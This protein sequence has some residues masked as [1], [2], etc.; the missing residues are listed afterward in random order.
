MI[1]QMQKIS[2]FCIGFLYVVHQGGRQNIRVSVE[3]VGPFLL[4][5]RAAG[6]KSGRSDDTAATTLSRPGLYYTEN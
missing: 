3:K 6:S 4:F 2:F 1:H 5:D